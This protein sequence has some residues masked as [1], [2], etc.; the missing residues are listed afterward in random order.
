MI[1]IKKSP[2]I[3]WFAASLISFLSSLS[4][5]CG[6]R[7]WEMSP[8]KPALRDALCIINGSFLICHIN[9]PEGRETSPGYQRPGG[10]RVKRLKYSFFGSYIIQ[11]GGGE[12]FS[13]HTILKL[14]LQIKP[15]TSWILVPLNSLFSP[16]EGL[17][18]CRDEASPTWSPGF[19]GDCFTHTWV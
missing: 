15:V 4:L 2:A 8:T 7:Q 1:T 13:N 10:E 18:V 19:C 3:N 14:S 9:K 5:L 6:K 11:L 17:T 16:P 12:Q